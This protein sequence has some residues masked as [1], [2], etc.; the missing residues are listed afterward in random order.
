M[1]LD[2]ITQLYKKFTHTISHFD[3][4][5]PLLLRLYLA[6][7]FIQAGWNKLISFESTVQWFG[8][9]DW[10]LGLPFPELM[11]TLYHWHLPP[12]I[13]KKMVALPRVNHMSVISAASKVM[14]QWLAELDD[15][16]VQVHTVTA[17]ATAEQSLTMATGAMA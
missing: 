6:P 9:A 15:K 14:P 3:G 16:I 5:A 13:C 8:N 1:A 10:G 2:A 12:N 7:I 4:L 17:E 11:A